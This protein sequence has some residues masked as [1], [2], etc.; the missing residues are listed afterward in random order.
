MANKFH[1]YIK[2]LIDIITKTKQAGHTYM[3]VSKI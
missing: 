3:Y 1:K 2:D